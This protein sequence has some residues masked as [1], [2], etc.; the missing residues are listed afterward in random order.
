MRQTIFITAWLCGALITSAALSA[1]TADL[2]LHHARIVTVDAQFRIVDSIA[3]RGERII[4]VGP[5]AEV[6]KLAG[7]ATRQPPHARRGGRVGLT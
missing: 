1:D 5:H 7:P 3:I 6:A 4:A 2:I